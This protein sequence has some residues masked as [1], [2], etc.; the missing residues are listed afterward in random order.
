[1]PRAGFETIQNVKNYQENLITFLGYKN[2]KSRFRAKEVISQEISRLRTVQKILL[3]QEEHLFASKSIISY[4]HL[5]QKIEEWNNSGASIL[6]SNNEQIYT[7]IKDIQDTI[8][9]EDFNNKLE[10]SL[11]EC[12]AR[13]V[14]KDTFVKQIKSDFNTGF[15]NSDRIVRTEL[16]YTQNQACFHRY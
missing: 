2:S 15:Y 7:L 9:L 3:A 1:M 14:S 8:Q 12:V 6:L 5:L 4:E 11:I 10:Q 16:N 13:G